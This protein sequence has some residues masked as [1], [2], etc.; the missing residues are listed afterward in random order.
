MD[1]TE[2]TD[3]KRTKVMVYGPPKSGK[4]A[5]VGSLAAAGFKLW[6]FDCENGIKTLLNPEILAP[7]HR[8]NV[9]VFNIPDHRAL[10]IAVDVFRKLFKG[11]AYKF[12]Y[13]HGVANCPICQKNAA[14]KWSEPIDL[15]KFGDKDILVIDSWS[16]VASSALNKVT[17]KAWQSDP[18]YKITFNDFGNQGMY[19]TEILSKIQVAN[20]NIC[21]ISH[22]VDVEK[23]EG[24]ERI[25]PVGGT[26]NF[27]ATI[28]KYFDEIIYAYVRNK[29]HGAAS[30][31]TWDNIHLTGGRSGVKMEDPSKPA[32]LVDVFLPRTT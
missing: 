22:E 31:T 16:Q 5:M 28:G 15:A 32:S 1:L 27:S 26:R 29:K 13:E 25:V 2:Y 18:E 7:E 11:G 8:K 30:S 24:K 17:L 10:P 3:V 9:S 14:A 12:C 6:W 19:L 20:I 4:T 23:D 21:V